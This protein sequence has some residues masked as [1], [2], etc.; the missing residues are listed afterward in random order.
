VPIIGE[1]E[2]AS[3][4]LRG[5]VIAITGTKGKSTT[6]TLIGRMLQAAVR[7]ARRRQHRRAAERQVEA[8]TPDTVHVVEVSSFQLES[9]T[10]FQAVDCR[11]AQLRPTISI[12]TRPSTPT[13]RRR[14]AS[15]RT[16]AEDWAVV[17][18]DDPS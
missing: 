10:T 5:R 18:A 14:R 6:T 7:R 3:R 4:W 9:T 17:N 15:S 13:R 8:S 11:L 16:S 12:G 2:L 1:L